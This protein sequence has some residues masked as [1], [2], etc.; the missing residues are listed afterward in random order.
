ME[1][2]LISACLLGQAVRYNGGDKRSDDDILQRWLREGRVVS[3]CPEVAGGL[4]VPR[5]PAEIANGAGGEHVLAGT[6]R[7]FA[8]TTEDVTAEFIRG[9]DVAY[10]LAQS[11]RIRVAVLKEGSPSCGSSYTYDGAFTGT[12]VAHPGVTTTRLQQAGLHV[13]SEHQFAEADAL[14]EQLEAESGAQA[15]SLSPKVS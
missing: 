4:A 9:A 1:S 14:L 10:Q 7:V 5:P 8:N 15:V 6:A 3:V 12:R 13:F 11:H 2:V